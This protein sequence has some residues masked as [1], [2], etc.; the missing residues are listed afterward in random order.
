MAFGFVNPEAI[1][2]TYRDLYPSDP[3]ARRALN[4]CF[5]LDAQLSRV[6]AAAREAC[7]RHHAPTLAAAAPSSPRP[8]APNFVDLWRAAGQGH[9]VQNDIRYEQQNERYRRPTHN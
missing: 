3:E 2:S 1:L 8:P 7:Y 9:M 6:D 5:T 4:E